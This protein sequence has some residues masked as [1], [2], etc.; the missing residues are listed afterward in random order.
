MEVCFLLLAVLF[1][2]PVI[3]LSQ[4]MGVLPRPTVPYHMDACNLAVSIWLNKDVAK[5]LF[6]P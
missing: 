1:Y 3:A 6:K 5:D 2:A 4:A